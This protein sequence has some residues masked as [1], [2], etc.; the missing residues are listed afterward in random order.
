MF[1]GSNERPEDRPGDIIEDWE[2]TIEPVS[3][4]RTSLEAPGVEP[5][6]VIPVTLQAKVTEVGTL[7]ISLVSRDRN[8]KFDLEFDV[9]S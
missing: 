6:T 7:A 2:E 9:R 5:G 4:L 8:L 1:L 3:T